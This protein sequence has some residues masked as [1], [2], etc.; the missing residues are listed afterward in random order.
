MGYGGTPE[1]ARPAFGQRGDGSANVVV[2]Q[3][4]LEVDEIANMAINAVNNVS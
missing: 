4:R 3:D 1:V 2:D